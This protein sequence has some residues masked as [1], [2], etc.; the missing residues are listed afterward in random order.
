MIISASRRTDIPAYYGEWFMNRLREN[1]VLVRNPFNPAYISRIRLIEK[2]IDCIVF[3]TKN[4]VPF[5]RWL[6]RIIVPYY[7]LFTITGYGRDLEKSIPEKEILVDS[8]IQL[9]SICGRERV[10]WRYD[11]VILTDNFTIEWHIRN[12][13]DLATQLHS[14]TGKCIF[15]FLHLYSK[16]KTSLKDTGSREITDNEKML[17][18][19]E[20]A[21]I[22]LSCHIELES[23]ATETELSMFGIRNGSCINKKIIENITGF[24]LKTCKDKYQRKHCGCIE[25]IDIGAYN[26]CPGH[27]LYCY[28]NSGFD[29]VRRNIEDHDPKSSLLTGKLSGSDQIFDRN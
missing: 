22:A 23:C 11:P 10:I 12:F 1:Y 24:S 18:S 16:C 25:S 21:K 19:A 26:T 4:P 6:P 28:A 20:M 13:A 29:R 9:S 17:L 7:F 5:I 3:W 15:S 14:Y 2:E 8:F 27:C